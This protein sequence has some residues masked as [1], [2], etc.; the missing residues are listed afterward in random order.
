MNYRTLIAGPMLAL[1]LAAGA[2]AATAAPGGMPKGAGTPESLVLKTFGCH[3]SCE[4]G[5]VLRWHRHVGPGC[6]PV[7]CYPRAPYPHRCW[8]DGWGARHCRW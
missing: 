5:P 4:W 3:R 6:V 8:V 1:A 2:S 7:G